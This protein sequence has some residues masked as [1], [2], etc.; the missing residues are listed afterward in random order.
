MD[1]VISVPGDCSFTYVYRGN[2][3][4]CYLSRQGLGS[5]LYRFLKRRTIVFLHRNLIQ[6]PFTM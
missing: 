6:V 1:F 5:D 2:N 4:Y 3:M